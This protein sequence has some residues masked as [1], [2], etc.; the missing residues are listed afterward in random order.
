MTLIRYNARM[1]RFFDDFFTK[2][3]DGFSVKYC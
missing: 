3:M 1:P 2:E